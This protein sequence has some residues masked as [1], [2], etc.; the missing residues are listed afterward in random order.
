MASKK[1]KRK[2]NVTRKKF[3]GKVIPMTI[4][5][6]YNKLYS[7]VDNEKSLACFLANNSVIKD[8][9]FKTFHFVL[10]YWKRN[11]GNKWSSI[12]KKSLLEKIDDKTKTVLQ[13][14]FSKS[15]CE[16]IIEFID[17]NK[18]NDFLQYLD[19]KFF[20]VTAALNTLSEPTY[21][22][23]HV[24]FNVDLQKTF[25]KELKNIMLIK[26]ISWK[27]IKTMYDSLKNDKDRNM[28]NFFIFDIIYGADKSIDSIYRT[29]LGNMSF[30]RERLSSFEHSKSNYIKISNCNKSIIVDEDY[31]TYGIYN[32]TERYKITKNMPYAKI[33]TKFDSPFIGGPSGSTAVLYISLFHFYKYPFTKKNKILLLGTLIADYIPLWHTI[34]EILLSAYPEFKDKKIAKYTL[35]KNPVLYSI[36]LLKPFIQ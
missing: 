24:D 8:F 31:S 21:T 23:Y 34:P 13:I 30:F 11:T 15:E 14:G 33:M 36:N 18:I 3:T 1:A 32:S 17:V 16:T 9:A 5:T 10:S 28:Y 19:D 27:D 29:N 26:T 6:V 7:S 22:V 20:K 35:D 4:T 2:N 25:I 12:I